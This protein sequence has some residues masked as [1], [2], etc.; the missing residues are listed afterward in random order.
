MEGISAWQF[1]IAS[2]LESSLSPVSYA[3]TVLCSAAQ[4]EHEACNVIS[5]GKAR[6]V[7]KYF[8]LEFSP[9]ESR[10][11]RLF[12]SFLSVTSFPF[13]CYFLKLPK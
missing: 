1:S 5:Q 7:T 4:A 13:H 2:I 9:T 10:P 11:G 12:F 8:P 6:N 3:I